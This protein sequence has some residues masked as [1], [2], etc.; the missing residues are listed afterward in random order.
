M[1]IPRDPDAKG[2]SFSWRADDSDATTDRLKQALGEV[3]AE[4][5]AVVAASRRGVALAKRFED[6]GQMLDLGR[7]AS[8]PLERN[9]IG[10][11]G[12][13]DERHHSP[14]QFHSIECVTDRAGD[15]EETEGIPLRSDALPPYLCVAELTLDRRDEPYQILFRDESCAPAFMAA[16]AR[17]SPTAPDTMMNGRSSPLSRRTASAGKA[18]NAGRL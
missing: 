4:T 6:D 5:G 16:T 18:L 2:G 12:A 17:S 3:Q 14:K 15:R 11:E 1:A 8:I 10:C 7:G 9:R 13:R